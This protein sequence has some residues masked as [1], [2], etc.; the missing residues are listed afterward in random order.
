MFGS[1]RTPQRVRRSAFYKSPYAGT[2]NTSILSASLNMSMQTSILGETPNHILEP[3]PTAL[4]VH[5]VESLLTIES[6]QSTS[7]ILSNSW[8]WLVVKSRLLVFQHTK[9][10]SSKTCFSLELPNS[11]LLHQANLCYIGEGGPS[12]SCM[13]VS[14]VGVIRY[15]PNISH[16]SAYT[17]TSVD[18]GGEECFQ[19]CHLGDDFFVVATTTGSLIKVAVLGYQGNVTLD[20]RKVRIQ[21]G[22][23]SEIGKKMSSL[24]FGAMPIAGDINHR[25]ARRLL[26]RGGDEVLIL[27]EKALQSWTGWEDGQETP[28]Y[29]IDLEGMVR[30]SF[31]TKVWGNESVGEADISTWCIDA[32]I[33]V[34]GVLVLMAAVNENLPQRLHY[35]LAIIDLHAPDELK[36]FTPLSEVE[37]C[38]RSNLDFLLAARCLLPHGREV[39]VYT[40]HKIV[41]VNL[42]EGEQD[43]L[44]LP[45]NDAILGCGSKDG[46]PLLL[47]QLNHLVILKTTGRQLV[48]PLL[49]EESARIAESFIDKDDAPVSNAEALLRRALLHHT[50]GEIVQSQNLLDQVFPALAESPQVEGMDQVFVDLSK[51]LLNDIPA[52]DPRWGKKTPKGTSVLIENHI[53]D[54]IKTLD[55]MMQFL[56][57]Y[58][59]WKKFTF[60]TVDNVETQTRLVLQEHRELLSMAE[61]LDSTYEGLRPTQSMLDVAMKRVVKK[62]GEKPPKK[63]ITSRDLCFVRVYDIS[64]LLVETQNYLEE[65]IEQEDEFLLEKILLTNTLFVGALENIKSLREQFLESEAGLLESG[66]YLPWTARRL[67]DVLIRQCEICEEHAMAHNYLVGDK[68]SQLLEQMSE[69]T[70]IVLDDY[71]MNVKSL[72]ACAPKIKVEKTRQ[73]MSVDRQKLI[74]YFYKH[75]HIDVAACLAEEFFEFPL[76]VRI[77]EETGQQNKLFEYMDRFAGEN[78]SEYVFQY[79]VDSGKRDKLLTQPSAFNAQLSKFLQSHS[80]LHWLHS[81]KTGDFLKACQ[82]LKQLAEREERLLC[83]KKLQVSIAKLAALA[84]TDEQAEEQL[85]DIYS[86]H[87]I[88]AIQESLSPQILDR[89]GFT[90]ETCPVLKPIEMIKFICDSNSKKDMDYKIALDLLEFVA[91]DE[92]PA[93]RRTIWAKAVLQDD[94]E[95]QEGSYITDIMR[96]LLFFQ[97]IELG[98]MQD[99]DLKKFMPAIEDLLESELLADIRNSDSFQYILH[100]GYEHIRKM[101]ED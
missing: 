2:V 85:Q 45:L 86:M 68:K 83:R 79:Y 9:Q 17:E 47:T 40:R 3:S 29:D 8:A 5:I 16:E 90:P 54:K 12:P 60:V 81:I 34:E 22:V 71:V 66:E 6:P 69:M 87:D 21:H 74:G 62:R 1:P 37:E 84:S 61:G 78:F 70:R 24:L 59:I 35:A 11:I 15:W 14:P 72:V 20:T 67:R 50:R 32:Q 95:F 10:I 64:D 26:C 57:V 93:L 58:G 99:R 91:E 101:A 31:R 100:G 63:S 27:F 23:F 96:D 38:T 49:P 39:F 42:I 75:K 76:L 36:Y 46:Q 97:I 43:V 55:V 19:L 52:G 25:D 73:Q 41:C 48:E 89:N 4:P 44:R 53:A 13:V 51:A 30:T 92:R 28:R 77:C 98:F 33:C 82:S 7:V 80:N 94:W 88:I 56:K 65:L 18:M